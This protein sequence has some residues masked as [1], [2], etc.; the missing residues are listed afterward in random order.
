MNEPPNSRYLAAARASA[1]SPPCGSGAGRRRPYPRCRTSATPTRAGRERAA[2]WPTASSSP[3]T[4]GASRGSCPSRRGR[5]AP[6]RATRRVPRPRPGAAPTGSRRR[7]QPDRRPRSPRPPRSAHPRDRWAARRTPSPSRREAE[8]RSG[9]LPL[10]ALGLHGLGELGEDLVE[11]AHDTQV[12]ELEDRRVRVL[13]DRDDVLG[14]LHADLVLD[15]PGDAR[16]Q[17]QLRRD[18]LAGLADLG[19]VRVPAGVDDGTCGGNRPTE[20]SG[21]LL[22]QLESL[23]VA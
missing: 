7:A 4:G 18:G 10:A 6:R 17:V 2:A 9:L 22:A 5:S 23:G 14:A 11:I 16:G 12:G 8:T 15:R 20:R 3:R 1:G 13:V 21:E 19:G